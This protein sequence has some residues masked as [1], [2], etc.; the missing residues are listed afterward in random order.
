MIEYVEYWSMITTLIPYA[1]LGLG[2]GALNGALVYYILF[3]NKT[4]NL[5]KSWHNGVKVLPFLI[6]MFIGFIFGITKIIELSSTLDPIYKMWA[7]MLGSGMIIT[8]YFL[9]PGFGIG[10]VVCAF[11]RKYYKPSN[12]GDNYR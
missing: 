10:G 6:I 5:I 2:V 11:T 9:L 7:Y 4:L 1:I 12:F 8:G 3:Y